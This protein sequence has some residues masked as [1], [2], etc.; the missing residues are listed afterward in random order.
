MLNVEEF[1]IRH[2]QSASQINIE[3][4][5]KSLSLYEDLPM[6]P[7]HATL[8][9]ADG[10][11]RLIR[12][13]DVGGTNLRTARVCVDPEGK[14]TFRDFKVAPVPGLCSSITEEEFYKAIAAFADL[15]H[16][17]APVRVS[18][19]Y[20][21]E[22]LP[23]P[24]ARPLGWCKEINITG[25]SPS[26]VGTKLRQAANR[27]DLDIK[28]INDAVA[29]MLSGYPYL[30]D[31]ESLLGLIVGS[32]FNICATVDGKI[33]NTEAGESRAFEPGDFERRVMME[34]DDP[35]AAQAEKQ[36]A[37]KYLLSVMR[38]AF[39]QAEKE[40]LILDA[41]PFI[42]LD[43]PK[44]SEYVTAHQTVEAEL[45]KALIRRAAAITA[46]S[47]SA[48]MT[49]KTLI[50]LEGS[51]IKKLC[52]Y[53]AAF[54]ETLRKVLPNGAFRFIEPDNPCLTGVSIFA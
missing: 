35:D 9:A 20:N 45:Y 19:A 53:R 4:A 25:F 39:E 33:V 2:G 12:A 46:I 48:F 18:Y 29:N 34:S 47:C 6:N 32:G 43:Y 5:L 15:K 7:S 52:G 51:L 54:E 1:L 16:E 14:I 26:S 21:M 24:D 28:V 17:S 38:H 30:R 42:S 49:E 37:G 8:T 22:S 50:V 31:G 11:A 23:G 13:I 44:I 27:P 10:K 36:T 3:K 41:E 40:G